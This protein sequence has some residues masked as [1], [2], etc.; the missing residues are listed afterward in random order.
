MYWQ[1]T[2]DL[3]D[4][5]DIIGNAKTKA[6]F[7]ILKNMNKDNI[8]VGSIL[9]I[10]EKS[11]IDRRTVKELFNELQTKTDKTKGTPTPM[12][13]KIRSNEWQLSPSLTNRQNKIGKLILMKEYLLVP[14]SPQSLTRKKL[15]HV[16]IE[17]SPAI[18]LE[19]PPAIEDY[20]N[21]REQYL[22]LNPKA[23]LINNIMYRV[24]MVNGKET[25]HKVNES[26]M[27]SYIEIKTRK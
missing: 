19:V 11:G 13:K 21:L 26:E 7:Y 9:Y 12:I 8:I 24:G 16:E 3:L 2:E 1:Y 22:K 23:K 25:K 18:E 20:A 15:Q 14:N 6:L 10:S 17:V 27:K 4:M 5:L